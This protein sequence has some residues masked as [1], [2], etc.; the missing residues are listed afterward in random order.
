MYLVES[1]GDSD[2]DYETASAST[3]NEN[4]DGKADGG[5]DLIGDENVSIEGEDAT[6]NNDGQLNFS[7][8][9]EAEEIA[10]N[11]KRQ[12]NDWEQHER[13]E[14]F[15]EAE[16]F[17]KD[18]GFARFDRKCLNMGTKTYYRCDKIS[19]DAKIKCNVQRY[20]F[21]PND[22]NGYQIWKNSAEHNHADSAKTRKGKFSPDLLD[23][24]ITSAK[25]N[26]KPK[27]IIRDINK[28]RE[29]KQR[30]ENDVTPSS[31]QIHYLL[32]KHS[33]KE[34]PP[35]VSIGELVEWCEERAA[36]P[37]N[38]DEAFV[39]AEQHS[40]HKQNMYFRFVLSTVRLLRNAANVNNICVDATY[41]LNWCGFPLLL[42]GT[43]D[44][45]KSFHLIAI[46]CC[47]NEKQA[48]F[49]FL[50]KT[51][52]G[53][54]KD[55]L[56]FELKPEIMIADAADAIRNAFYESFPESATTDIMCYA[57]VVR[58]VKKRS[59]NDKKNR[60]KI[61]S[62]M[63]ILH[64]SKNE[65]L[66]R[67]LSTL[68]LAKWEVD[69]PDFAA[70]F[71]EYWLGRHCNWFEGKANYTPTHN[72]A[73]ESINNV[74]KNEITER[75]RL[76]FGQFVSKM[77]SLCND[78]STDYKQKTKVISTEPSTTL[79]DIREAAIYAD[80]IKILL[81]LKTR[82]ILISIVF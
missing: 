49:S 48:D 72:N 64:L 82:R 77:C 11:K 24:L 44:L 74:I 52:S 76:P 59:L 37:K 20:I 5:N 29:E 40:K 10:M 7:I 42:I 1:D 73:C 81:K 14:T 2:S 47:S 12:C 41:K 39:L 17:V 27:R 67:E 62:D 31:R 61:V 60:T 63:H 58:N 55:L 19:R 68:F 22:T 79:K 13:F 56:G 9:S 54:V 16:K 28:M 4:D 45:N 38:N 32:A 35:I 65:M 43:I 30:F 78:F 18:H 36:T 15:V 6:N 57:H 51:V 53:T 66:F 23:F 34:A 69:E 26:H 75:K 80:S 70:Y 50:F 33:E 21:A 46:A 3:N 71:D 25:N 8:E